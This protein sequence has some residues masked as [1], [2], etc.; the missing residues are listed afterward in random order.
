MFAWF[1]SMGEKRT[2]RAVAEIM[3]QADAARHLNFADDYL[4]EKNGSVSDL[5]RPIQ[6]AENFWRLSWQ[7]LGLFFRLF[8][9]WRWQEHR[10]VLLSAFSLQFMCERTPAFGTNIVFLAFNLLLQAFLLLPAEI[11]RNHDF[12]LSL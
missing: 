3:R 9:S 10:F 4:F 5:M 6:A 2:A 1:D 7:W 8:G 12:L 11:A